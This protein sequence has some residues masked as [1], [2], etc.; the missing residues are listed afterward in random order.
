MSQVRHRIFCCLGTQDFDDPARLMEL[1]LLFVLHFNF[2][3]SF[4]GKGHPTKLQ[5]E[6]LPVH[7]CHIRKKKV[8]QNT[9]KYESF[10]G[11]GH[12]QLL[13]PRLGTTYCF[14]LRFTSNILFNLHQLLVQLSERDQI[15]A[16]PIPEFPVAFHQD[17]F[18]LLLQTAWPF[19]VSLGAFAGNKIIGNAAHEPAR[20]AKTYADL[21][22]YLVNRFISSALTKHAA[23]FRLVFPFHRRILCQVVEN[24]NV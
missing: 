10:S 15:P 9:R 4:P 7:Y 5:R 16:D 8:I 21:A 22:A 1:L 6:M 13:Q 24:D 14:H 12:A 23:A 3:V 17:L 20:A 19:S 11:S 2:L 18:V